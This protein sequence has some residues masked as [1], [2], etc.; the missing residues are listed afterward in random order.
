MPVKVLLVPVLS[1]KARSPEWTLRLKNG[2]RHHRKALKIMTRMLDPG[3]LVNRLRISSVH[4]MAILEIFK[5]QGMRHFKE[6]SN[7]IKVVSQNAIRIQI[8]K[9]KW[10]VL[11]LSKRF[12]K[13]KRNFYLERLWGLPSVIYQEGFKVGRGFDRPGNRLKKLIFT[14]LNLTSLPN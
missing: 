10:I 5:F 11:I 2:L 9:K 4:L 14:Q 7:R 8:S 12:T 13:R 3:R 1:F 6:N